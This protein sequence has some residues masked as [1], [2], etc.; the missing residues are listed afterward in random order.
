MLRIVKVYAKKAWH[1]LTS[2]RTALALLFLLAIAAIPGALLPQRSLNETNVI[3]YIENNGRLAE[4]YDRLQL[5]DVFSSS[6]F[7]AIY[8]LLLL[9]LVGCILPRSWD[10]YQA[11][12]APVVRAPRNL[13]RL[14]HH[15]SGVVDKPAEAV[16]QDARRLLKGWKVTGY[17]AEEDRAGVRS[18]AAE[19]GYSRELYNLIFHLGIV[20]VILTAGLG[21]IFYYE[22]QVIVVTDGDQH[23]QNSVFCNTATAN[24]D[25][26]RAG[27][28]FDGTGLTPF[29]FEA[30]DFSADYLPNGQ[31]EMFR[32]NISYAVGADINSDPETWTDYE[33]R[34]NHPLRIEGDRV[35]LQG[36]GFA[37]TFTV[38]WPNGETRTQ[39]VQWRPDDPTFFL[40]SGVMRF[41][42]PAGMY[43]DLYERRQN[44]L[45][46]QGLFAPTAAWE[47]DNDELLTSAYPAMRDPAVAID[48]YRGDNG[49]DTGIGQSLFTLDPTLMHSGQLQKI[50]RVNLQV[51]DSVTLDD[52]TVVTFDGAS[53]FANYQVSRDP[54][55]N[56]VLVT[57]TIALFALV[58][59]LTVRRRR[60]WIRLHPQADGGT[61]VETGGLARTDRAGWGSEYEDLH[62]ELLGL[63]REDEDEELYFDDAD[64]AS[65]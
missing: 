39:T 52:G 56:W 3:E 20:G 8:V 65:R 57:T 35:Y 9:S 46:I 55:Q 53:E 12:R 6:W 37:P 24:Y 49:L 7:T 41:D 58:G 45:A 11:M 47:G 25:S 13:S 54:T 31:A 40:S 21:R 59:S 30:H 5:F 15:G 26:F 18:L 51:G 10:H 23:S 48:I 22:G 44:Q 32:S 50:E 60:I 27:A 61:R 2:M 33:L 19:K 63:Q 4:F 42:P 16:E 38:A 36:H 64:R 17:S 34:V 28:S 29:C 62:A 1:W 43:P 14:S